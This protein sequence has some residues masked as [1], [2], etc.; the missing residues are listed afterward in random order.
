MTRVWTRMILL[1]CLALTLAPASAM[2]AT[3]T[4][5]PNRP[6]WLVDGSGPTSAGTL[7]HTG[8]DLPRLVLT[9]VV[10]MGV[11]AALRV[12]ASRARG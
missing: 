5:S 10:L 4:L 11:G 2:G 9:G 7:P 6:P 8:T 3:G 12:G 1:V